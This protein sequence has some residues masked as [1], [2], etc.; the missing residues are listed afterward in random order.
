MATPDTLTLAER[1]NTYAAVASANPTIR[2]TTQEAKLIALCLAQADNHATAEAHLLRSAEKV[3]VLTAD[4][5]AYTE[6]RYKLA[7]DALHN[8]LW[9]SASILLSSLMSIF[10]L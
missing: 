8:A 5:R 1:F 4:L 6:R 9:L 7:D 10:L 3:G 2:L